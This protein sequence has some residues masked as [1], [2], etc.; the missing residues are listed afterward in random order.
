[1]YLGIWYRA[2]WLIG[3]YKRE[4]MLAR[5]IVNHLTIEI[6]RLRFFCTGTSS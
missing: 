5:S 4:I 6:Q 2:E 1:M 3:Y